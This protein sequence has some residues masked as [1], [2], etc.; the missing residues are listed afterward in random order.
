MSEFGSRR[1]MWLLNHSAARKFEIPM[2][3]RI[4]FREFFLPKIFPNDI[5]FRSANVDFS[6]DPN[7]T[8]PSDV[9]EYF[10]TLD[11]YSEQ[12]RSVWELASQ[13]FDVAFY[14]N[15]DA[16]ASASLLQNFAGAAMWRAYGLD[17]SLTYSKLALRH[18]DLLPAILRSRQRFWFAQAYQNIAK[19]EEDFLR[20]RSIYL[21]LGMPDVS[22]K[23]SWQ[24]G[25]PRILFVCPDLGFNPYYQEAYRRF[26]KHF[27]DLPYVVGGAQPLTV[28]N[29]KV[30]GFLSAEEYER[31]MRELRVMYYHSREPRHI[32]YHPFEA[33]RAGMPLIFMAGGLLDEL[34]GRDLPGRCRTEGEA[35]NKV[36]R[37]LDG[38]KRFIESVRQ[39]Q[40]R[41]LDAMSSESMVPQWQRA[42][43]QVVDTLDESRSYVAPVMPRRRRI[44]VLVPVKYRGGSLRG[45]KLLAQALRIGSQK[46]GEDVEVV[47][48]HLDDAGT[49]TDA[50]FADLGPGI[51]V[52]PYRWRQIDRSTAA[53]A[54]VYEGKNPFLE[55]DYYCVPEDGIQHF[56]DCDLWVI[57]SDRLECPLLPLRP[58]VLMV[59]DYLQRY[60]P[61]MKP[62][63]DEV[64]LYAARQA[65]RVLVTTE[66]TGRDAVGYAGVV[67]ERVSKVPMLVPEVRPASE[68]RAGLTAP[69]FLWSTNMAPHK[70][71]LTAVRA[72]LSYYEELN[73]QLDCVVTGVNSRG[74]R[75]RE[76]ENVREAAQIIAESRSLKSRLKLLGELPDGKYAAVMKSARFYWHPTIID[77]GTFSV[78]EAARLGVPSL[79]SNYPAMREMDAQFE[80]NLAYA[81]SDD[82]DSIAARLRWMEDNADQQ[83]TLLPAEEVFER[84]SVDS[85]AGAYW[86]AVGD[87][88]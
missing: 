59:Y 41:L 28:R 49:Y 79:S 5:S 29:P 23:D 35:R 65:R 82:P 10:N 57:V 52:R 69:Y 68:A 81:P 14:I 3:K 21:P 9:L 76:N 55:H 39:S 53:R 64:F 37:I 63:Q 19:I 62:G 38:D 83:R 42:M 17:K 24:G 70:N 87:L 51:T 11:W 72:L 84:N 15:V 4:G 80:L 20:R 86:Q 78:V 47:L 67:A 61:L 77:N 26:K 73:G 56:G 6:E 71:H 12:P 85:V 27:G 7:L 8:I 50:D 18:P 36:K 33:V 75:N 45:A 74:L 2:L 32:H 13:H 66:F 22:M 46:A 16:A 88:L 54:M 58:S 30:L 40:S 1:V 48:G 25:D 31:N 60:V 43:T 44:A 34:G